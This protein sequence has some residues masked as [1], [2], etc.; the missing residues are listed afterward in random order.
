M[1]KRL[2]SPLGIKITNARHLLTTESNPS[3][4]QAV[5]TG[6]KALLLIQVIGWQQK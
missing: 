2:C 5:N 4:K 3:L 6:F 1:D